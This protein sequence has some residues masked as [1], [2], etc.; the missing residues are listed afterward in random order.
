MLLPATELDA[1]FKVLDD[2][3]RGIEACPF[4]FKGAPLTITVS[5]GISAFSGKDSASQVFE[6]ADQALYAAKNGGR[7]QVRKAETPSS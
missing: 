3:R 5:C 7:N 4:H 2:L 1:G 6:R